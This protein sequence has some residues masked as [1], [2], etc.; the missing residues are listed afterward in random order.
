M[1]IRFQ[2]LTIEKQGNVSG[3]FRIS[4]L[5]GMDGIDLRYSGSLPFSKD[6]AGRVQP[7]PD[8]GDP[9]TP[10]QRFFILC[11]DLL[12]FANDG[13][14]VPYRFVD[15][16]GTP[17]RMDKSSVFWLSQTPGWGIETDLDDPELLFVRE[18][19]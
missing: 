2:T 11:C 17:W 15:G 9:D 5:H 13:I 4:G 8:T 10:R 16:A 14:H 1:R 6:G 12:R 3:A 19:I 18:P 7:E